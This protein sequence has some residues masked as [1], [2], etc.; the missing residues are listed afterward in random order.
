MAAVQAVFEQAAGVPIT[1]HRNQSGT[2]LKLKGR[3]LVHCPDG[4]DPV[5]VST[6]VTRDQ[7]DL[8]AAIPRAFQPYASLSQDM[9]ASHVTVRLPDDTDL[10]GKP[11]RHLVEVWVESAKRRQDEARRKRQRRKEG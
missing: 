6:S 1:R 3:S 2:V 7:R 10:E 9:Y 8:F 4:K 11:F 5:L